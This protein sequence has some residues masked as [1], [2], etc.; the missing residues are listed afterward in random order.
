[1]FFERWCAQESGKG[2]LWFYRDPKGKVQGP[3]RGDELLNW[4]KKGYF[5][6]DLPVKRDR[7]EWCQLADILSVIDPSH[8][9]ESKSHQ[10]V[11]EATRP[12][13]A[14]P[15]G[16]QGSQNAHREKQQSAACD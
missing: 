11:R 14:T 15:S 4:F 16:S 9:S 6:V 12:S 7:G 13:R 1:M 2:D 5:G 3:W 8:A 10:S